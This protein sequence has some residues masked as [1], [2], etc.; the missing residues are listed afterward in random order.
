MRGEGSTR[1]SAPVT[2]LSLLDYGQP[3]LGPGLLA[4]GGRGLVR[5]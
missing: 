3:P 2:S 1:R 5:F 4:P